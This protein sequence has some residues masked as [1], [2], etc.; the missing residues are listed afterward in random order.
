MN[1]ALTNPA[2]EIPQMTA[3]LQN[4]SDRWEAVQ[5]RDKSADGQFVYA[6]RTT[7]VFCHPSCP[8]RP[9]KRA[10]VAF[11]NS[12]TDA[13]AAGFRACKKCRPG[14]LSRNEVHAAAIAKACALMTRTD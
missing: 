9:A 11:Y 5:S 14:E 6:V 7:G 8:S 2:R 3:R 13:I 1:M 12:P 4:D 10:N